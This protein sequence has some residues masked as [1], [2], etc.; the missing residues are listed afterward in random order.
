MEPNE[1]TSQVNA[2]ETLDS[3]DDNIYEDPPRIPNVSTSAQSIRFK[4]P[5]S[6]GFSAYLLIND[7]NVTEARK[8]LKVH[9]SMLQH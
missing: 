7:D 2:N 3:D 4:F 1:S 5:K 8:L 9:P 6:A